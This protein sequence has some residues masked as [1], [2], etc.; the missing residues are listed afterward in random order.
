VGDAASPKSPRRDASTSSG[1][2]GVLE[3]LRIVIVD[4]DP[5]S[6]DLL[7]TVLEQRSALVFDA[8]TASDAFALLERERPDVLISDIAM[9]EEDG[10]EALRE[11][12]NYNPGMPVMLITGHGE[13]WLRMG[14]TLGRAHGLEYIE[15]AIKPIR[16]EAIREFLTVVRQ[17][18]K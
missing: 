4:D 11:I 7:Q 8:E 1:L 14:A 17:R 13:T 9:P 18:A 5:D 3:G 6:R 12:A 2:R 10:Y 15:T 16:A